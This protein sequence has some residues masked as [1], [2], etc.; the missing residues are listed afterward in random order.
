MWA[1]QEEV[2]PG[3]QVEGRGSGQGQGEHVAGKR[4]RLKEGDLVCSTH[5]TL[6]GLVPKCTVTV[7]LSR[8]VAMVGGSR[9]PV[10]ER[11]TPCLLSDSVCG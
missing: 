3:A 5:T 6:P 4:L 10:P 8:E 2:L 9:S 7:I 1:V 11:R